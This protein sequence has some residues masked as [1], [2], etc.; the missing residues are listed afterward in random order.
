MAEGMLQRLEPVEHQQALVLQEQPGQCAA[1][2]VRLPDR[3]AAMTEPGKGLREENLRRGIPPFVVSLAVERMDE[4]PSRAAPAAIA[5][6]SQ[7]LEHHPRLARSA[8]GMQ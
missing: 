5:Q 3:L 2:L 8:L 6:P 1:L 7:P 4:H